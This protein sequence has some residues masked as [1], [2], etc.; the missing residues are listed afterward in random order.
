MIVDGEKLKERRVKM[1]K[2]TI[3]ENGLRVLSSQ[4]VHT[5]SASICIYV[6]SG[7]RYEE[8]SQAGISHYVEH[9]LF[10]GTERRPTSIDI[11]G[12]IEGV[13]GIMN[14]STDREL[15]GY[16]CKVAL[17]H[18]LEGLDVLID[19]VCNSVFDATEIETE[20][21]VIQE[22]LGMSHDH[23]GYRADTLID[24]MMWPNQPL[25]RDVGGSKESVQGITRDML[26]DHFRRQYS[27]SNIVISVAGNLTHEQVVEAVALRFKTGSVLPALSWQPVV[28]YQRNHPQA[29]TEYRKAEQAHMCLG[30]PGISRDH[31]DRYRLD[32]MNT[33]LGEG[34]SSRL[35]SE[36]RERQGL[37]YDI[38]SSVSHLKDTGSIVV[39]CGV[40]P[41]KA[42]KALDTIIR[43]L[44]RM[45][46]G[47]SEEELNRGREL[48]KGR[49]LLSMEDTRA[50]AAWGGVQEMLHG[51]VITV[52][53]V[54][55]KV[56]AVNT[57]DL[58]D[59]AKKFLLM[60]KQSLAV[61]GPFRGNRKFQDLL[62]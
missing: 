30:L 1:Y 13:G 23:P 26:I 42:T 54:V 36:V 4:M 50:V 15:C 31:P 58:R 53:D 47:V 46:V 57:D 39:Y 5:M 60:E 6:G 9:M 21:T 29:R 34:M 35:F 27:P 61:V 18:F 14:G 51:Q 59:V 37:A 43:E 28:E 7:S 45:K 49:L 41:K 32:I 17:P 56:D 3:L 11:S 33:V 62:K 52:E 55:K 24:E 44:E 2:K 16:W 20:R 12:A 25:G 8:E 40:D 38:H 48:A 10:K 19:M 22:E